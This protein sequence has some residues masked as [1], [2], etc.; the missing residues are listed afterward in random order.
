MGV[1]WVPH[2]HVCINMCIHVKYDNFNCKLQPPLGNPWGFPMMSYAC[3]CMCTCVH[4]HV[5]VHM[6]GIPH[7]IDGWLSGLVD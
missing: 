4:T 2:T 7:H 3:A 6:C 1:W 5:H